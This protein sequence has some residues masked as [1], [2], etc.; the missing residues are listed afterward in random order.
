MTDK[1]SFRHDETSLEASSEAVERVLASGGDA[2]TAA[3]AAVE[4][5]ML[6]VPSLP[7]EHSKIVDEL[8]RLAFD[9][10]RSEDESKILRDAYHSLHT[11]WRREEA[12]RLDPLPLAELSRLIE[13]EVRSLGDLWD[14][15]NEDWVLE[16]HHVLTEPVCPTVVIRPEG[17]NALRFAVHAD[18]IAEGIV[19]SVALVRKDVLLGEPIVSESPIDNPDDRTW[20]KRSRTR[21]VDRD[22]PASV[23]RAWK[24]AE[25]LLSDAS[26][27]LLGERATRRRL[28][29]R[30]ADLEAGIRG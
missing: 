19:R 10:G 25:T 21:V 16:V 6:A 12:R 27:A 24:R 11:A 3:R 29:A 17:S 5:Y 13:D 30:I 23:R 22:D 15:T 7:S 20:P 4:A 8:M 9:D 2:A 1:P 26:N 28:E 14:R 18:T